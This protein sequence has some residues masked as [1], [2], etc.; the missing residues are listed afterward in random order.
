MR[1]YAKR[2]AKRIWFCFFIYKYYCAGA[3]KKEAG[4]LQPL[5]KR[6]H[7]LRFFSCF[8]DVRLMDVPIL[9]SDLAK[10]EFPD[11]LTDA[12]IYSCFD[13]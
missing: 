6:S 1:F 13:R 4:F 9:P 7:A 11:P 8:H 12:E 2:N 3:I 5:E 10:I